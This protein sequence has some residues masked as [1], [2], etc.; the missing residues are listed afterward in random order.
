MKENKFFHTFRTEDELL[1]YFDSFNPTEKALL[2]TSM[3][4]T[5]NLIVHLINKRK[6]ENSR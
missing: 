4:L 3:G 6:N 5:W 2:I 1:E